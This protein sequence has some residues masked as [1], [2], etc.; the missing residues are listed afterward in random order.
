MKNLFKKVYRFITAVLAFFL[1]ISCGEDSG[2]GASVDT[3]APVISITYPPDLAIIRKSFVFGGKWEDDKGVTSIAVEVYKSNSS[4]NSKTLVDSHEASIE[5]DGSWSVLLNDYDEETYASTNGWQYGDGSYVIQA[6]AKDS[7]GH[8]S[9]TSSRTFSIDNSAPVLVLSRPTTY[10]SEATPESYGQIVQFEGRFDDDCNK[11]SRLTVCFYDTNGNKLYSRDFTNITSMGESSPLTVARYYTES[12][13]GREAYPELYEAY[14]AIAGSENLT[15]YEN[16][17]KI[18]DIQVYFTLTVYDNAKIYTDMSNSDGEGEGNVSDCYYRGT[19]DMQNL[20][21]GDG[22][23]PDFTLADFADY[24]SGITSDWD[25]YASEI[26][27]VA[28]AARSFSTTEEKISN[29]TNDDST[30]G[31]NV[32]LTFDVNPDNS[33]TY[34][35]GGYDIVSASDAAEN[36]DNYSTAG[37][38]KAYSGAAYPVSITV[39]ADNKNIS[40]ATVSIYRVDTTKYTSLVSEEMFTGDTGK[41]NYAAGY[42]ELIWTW[43]AD[44]LQE[45]T[46]WGYDCSSV[47]TRTNSDANVSTL[48]K[49]LTIESFEAGHNYMFY[50]TGEDIAGNGIVYSNDYGYGF[51]GTTVTSAPVI[52]CTSG[53]KNNS[54]IKKSK[55]TGDNA[56]SLSDVLYESGTVSTD[57]KLTSLSYSVTLTDNNDSSNT[58]TKTY[59]IEISETDSEPEYSSDYTSDYCYTTNVTSTPIYYSWRFTGSAH[60]SDFESLIGSGD[61]EISLMLTANNGTS[62]SLQRT[63]TLD[64]QAPSAELSEISVAV[65]DKDSDDADFYWVNP[66]SALTLTGLIS[67]NLST[68]KACTTYVK[69]IP[70]SAA[71]LEVTADSAA[72]TSSSISGVNK[73]SFTVPA[74]TIAKTYYGANLY[75]YSQDGAGNTGVSTAVSLVFDTTAPEGVHKIDFKN[76]DIYFR[77]GE[78][79]NDSDEVSATEGAQTYSSDYD[80]DVGGKYQKG[81]YGNS[82]TLKIRGYFDESGSGVK[83]IYYKIFDSEP[84]S[85]ALENFLTNYASGSSSYAADGY[86]TPL[87]SDEEKQVLYSING[88]SDGTEK[89]SVIVKSNFKT[90][91]SGLDSA[92]NYLV[93]LAV[94]N[95]G[96]T[97][98]DTLEASLLSDVDSESYSADGKDVAEWNSSLGAFSL[99]VDSESPILVCSQ[100]GQQYTNGQAT[101]EVNGT[102]SDLPSSSANSGVSGIK[103][104]LNGEEI[105][106]SL[107]TS[108]STWSASISS[109]ILSALSDG[110]TYNVNGTI[111]DA[112]G[113]SS[114]ST[115]FTLSFDKAAPTVSV[116]SPSVSSKIN[117]KI[118]LSGTVAY[119]GAAPVKLE[120][121]YSTLTPDGDISSYAKIGTIT[122]SSKIY[123]WSF[124]DIDSYELTGVES[125]PKTA[126][127]YFIPVVTDSAGNT[128]VYDLTSSSYKYTSGSNYF[129]YTVDMDS[130]R[131]TVKVTNL[132]LSDGAYILKYGDNAKIEG[133]V[134]DDD[135]TSDAVVS[136]FIATT[137]QITSVS[138]LTSS[139]SGTTTTY[140]VSSGS[141]YDITTFD[142]S[143]GEWTFTPSDTSDGQKTVYFYITDNEET[144][145]YTGRTVTVNAVDYTY[146]SP[147]F[148]YKTNDAT[149][150]TSALSYRS[151]ST[152]P[153]IQNTLVQAYTSTKTSN[154][155]QESPGTS[156]TLGGIEKQY[157]KF[158]IT[159]YDANGI[160][161]IRLTL[162]YTD[163]NGAEQTLKIASSSDYDGF[164]QSGSTSGETTMVWT[165]DYIDLSDVKT[166]SVSGTIEV[167]DNSGLL[168]SSSP[169]FMVDN[170]GPEINITSPSSSEELTGSI[171]FSGTSND[172]G[173]AGIS[174]TSWLI[175][176]V[177]QTSLTDTALAALDGW[178]SELYGTSSATVWKFY[179]T[180]DILKEYDSET[181]TSSISDG[182][183]TLPFYLKTVDELGNYTI[184]RDFSFLH[185]PD[186]DRPVTSVTYPNDTDYQTECEY[187]TL[188]GAV[189]ISGSSYIPSATTTVGNVYLQIINGS[190]NIANNG[191]YTESSEYISSLSYDGS[192]CYTVS[193]AS[194]AATTLGL[195]GLTFASGVDSSTW[196][197]IK[198]N[199]TSSWNF[200]INSNGEMNPES[201]E[202]TYLAFRA[203]AIN[204]E[205]KV[206]TW[207]DWY[208]INIDNTAPT[209]T[210]SL[211]QYATSPYSACTSATIE[212]SGN[213]TAARN[214]ESEMYLRGNWYL[215]VKL[216][217]ES[218]LSSYSVAK[219]S[220]TLK[221]G[222]GYYASTLV[223][224][225]DGKEKTQYLFIPVDTSNA[226]VSYK[227]TVSDTEHSI[228]STY[229]L[230]IDNTAPSVDYVCKDSSTYSANTVLSTDSQN[231]VVD[232]NYVYTIGGKVTEEASGF[233]RLVFY[234][235][236]AQA[237]DGNTYTTETVLDPLITTGTDD[238]KAALAGLTK[239]TYTQGTE[240]YYLYAS[241]V[242]GTLGSDGYTFTPDT[243]SDITENAHI[244]EGGLIEAGGILRRIE[245]IDSSTGAVTFDSSTAV[246]SD[247]TATVYLPYAQVVDTSGESVSNQTTN[248]FTFKSD[249]GDLMPESLAGSTSIGYTWDATIHSYNI[250]DGPAALVVLAFDKAGNVSGT[251]YPVMVANNA[252]RLAKVFLGTDL[253][254][255]GSWTKSEFVGYNIYDANTTYGINTTEVKETQEIS[256]ASYGSAFKI[257]DKLAV[258]AE[259]VGG[260]GEI[261]MVWGKD[262]SSDSAVTV[263][264]GTE[265]TVNTALPDLVSEDKIGSVTYN[266][267][268]VST[269]LLGFTLANWQ[270]AGVSNDS[271]V[272][273]STDGSGKG[274][275]FTFWDSTDELVQGSTSQ[276]CV[277][278]VNDFTVDLVDGVNPETTI[279]PFYWAGTDDNSLYGNSSANGHI[280]LAGDLTSAMSTLY[281]SDPKVSGKIT[282]TGTSYDDHALKSIAFSFTGF[283]STGSQTVAT[284]TNTSGEWTASANTISDNGYEVTLTSADSETDAGNYYADSVYFSQAG[285]QVYWTISLDTGKIS[286]VAQKDCI[287]TVTTTDL[288]GR[289][290]SATYQM[291][292]VPYISKMTAYSAY[293]SDAQTKRTNSIRSRLGAVP[294][295]SSDTI[296][297]DGFNLSTSFYRQ[298]DSNKAGVS[299]L[300]DTLTG[301]KITENESYY[302]S[303]PAYSGYIIASTNSVYSLNNMNGDTEN[304]YEQTTNST[305]TYSAESDSSLDHYFDDRY[306]QVWRTDYVFADSAQ[307]I[308]PTME[309]FPSGGTYWTAS[310]TSKTASAGQVYGSWSSDAAMYYSESL[311]GSRGN[312]LGETS[313]KDSPDDADMCI[314]NGIPFYVILDNWQG[315]GTQWSG[316]GLFITRDNKAFTQS[317]VKDNSTTT[318][319]DY[320]IDVQ[321]NEDSSSPDSSDGL[322][323]M[324]F[325]FRNPKIAGTYSGGT[326]YTYACY[327]DNYAKC[328]KYGKIT[329]SGT[330]PTAVMRNCRNWTNGYTVVDGYDTTVTGYS[331]YA[332][333]VGK[334]SD[335]VLDTVNG[336]SAA[337]PIPVIA[338]CVTNVSSGEVSLRIAR[339][340]STSPST[341]GAVVTTEGTTPTSVTR[342]WY[343]TDVTSSSSNLIPS[344]VQLGNY[345]SMA[346]DAGGNLHIATQD[347][348]NGDLYYIYLTYSSSADS[349]YTVAACCKVD[350]ANSVGK[351]NDIKLEASS[352]SGSLYGLKCSPVISYLDATNIENKKA[353]KTAFVASST[354]ATA[355]VWEHMTAPATY[356]ANDEKTSLVL[357]A[358]DSGSTSC[359]LGIGYQ[360]ASFA[361]AFL[362]G[363]K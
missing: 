67:D 221:E 261:T 217:D 156:L 343:Y 66:S 40:T 294:V 157:A 314:I 203:C 210:A 200:T 29:L 279:H 148:Q 23:V 230:N 144:A 33:P 195:S 137:S 178:N 250:P 281:G 332:A 82:S 216:H 12:S 166:G 124:T 199:N 120:L 9:G 96:N 242:S 11:I 39:G 280:D 126:S 154:G 103:L 247:T 34:T 307:A 245:S 215:T 143:T 358:L 110:E 57:E 68:P 325:Q 3:E 255:N 205:G 305:N 169:V 174:E 262:A 25:E 139:T 189:R 94:D 353:V 42:F 232:S 146:L 204:A 350:S 190:A 180:T 59:T 28:N 226:S 101:I 2:L 331:D 249:D 334:Y 4:D 214:Y 8:S 329:W 165:T 196:W 47:Y 17:E 61:Y 102:F 26:D 346:I 229:S 97:A 191:S 21:A 322:D 308:S 238:S 108:S 70:L 272:A 225:T 58:L 194:G 60:S 77:V 150:N 351:W 182:V 1:I 359:K 175:P 107:D 133:S 152:A 201:G 266:N 35:I 252:P 164:T 224:G 83:M 147:Y 316:N 134:S 56:E 327:F 228:S 99:N 136:T 41:T 318:Y 46:D 145:F 219:G 361:T 78:T 223:T 268:T 62:S 36:T 63:F 246:D 24:L 121:Y 122:D 198:A 248:P 363:E 123:S 253:N 304:N 243:S 244:R 138:D 355:G 265:A 127:L 236:R 330:D 309:V 92:N 237:I 209:Q 79:D 271:S 6:V 345:V 7:A 141:S 213:I 172:T 208:Y 263:S 277:L 181:Y 125:S 211:K 186:A 104:K 88:N 14:K 298:L 18:D 171:T 283:N 239:R 278:Y 311:G 85:S 81:S 297:I 286:S 233:E 339:G 30:G 5:S 129:A 51:C 91:I 206:G 313:W 326:Y 142:S 55:F 267:N 50:V 362:R 188:G 132:T 335:I 19:Q 20:V 84:D 170:D 310:G 69:L 257:K 131:P 13:G 86:F 161:G 344:G 112:A 291:D 218:E 275:S 360:S 193:D 179:L 227:V 269:S 115:L 356:A 31:G 328:L 202:I 284:Y 207:T 153:S 87:D 163:S 118:S 114:S 303:A 338:Y 38:K 100:S 187:V 43:D 64:T 95:V 357:S 160:D 10:G 336:G 222:S 109:E 300:T 168:G 240:S 270:I 254:S 176:T 312:P 45:F 105:T 44:V 342:G 323:E 290:H 155:D 76:K 73:W 212:T 235:V 149:D 273:E 231:S 32:Y 302:I 184:Y 140:R 341:S 282:F 306:V 116:T 264:D 119:E 80:T 320:A 354:S 37:Y 52:S 49:Q 90:T 192:S 167:Y 27:S 130:D 98:L 135:A 333:N 349:G 324:M 151:D 111:S 162:T 71:N 276:N 220:S 288:S 74:D 15:A 337:S 296:V 234:Y 299:T 352:G 285:H 53:D 260:N 301:T 106:A 340:K 54:V 295:Q 93:L 259:I 16:G 173:N 197:G 158:I 65:E 258:V 348:E 241:P 89:R 274:G 315:S 256:T 75:V 72:Y 48:T 22:N 317:T 293:S 117:G 159:G 319:T 128:T 113:N 185:N 251:T 177:T 292:V 287:L 183:Y 321:G 347:A 289:T